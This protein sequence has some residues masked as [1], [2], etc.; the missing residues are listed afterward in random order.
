MHGH[1]TVHV[2]VYVCGAGVRVWGSPCMQSMV[3]TSLL[4]VQSRK[5]VYS[6]RDVP[7]MARAS[8]PLLVEAGIRGVSEGSNGR[9]LPGTACLHI[10]VL[11]LL[12]CT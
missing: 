5:T 7:G 10:T 1:A 2:C 8:I 11:R 3:L 12:A 4:M 6:Q 9:V